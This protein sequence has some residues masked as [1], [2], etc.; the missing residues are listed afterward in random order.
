MKFQWYLHIFTIRCVLS[1]SHL[2]FT[3]FSSIVRKSH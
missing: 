3:S 2:T 1:L